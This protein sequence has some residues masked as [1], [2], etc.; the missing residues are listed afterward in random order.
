MVQPALRLPSSVIPATRPPP[1]QDLATPYERAL[2]ARLALIA[3]T[4]GEVQAAFAVG[5]PLYR[6]R[7]LI[8]RSRRSVAS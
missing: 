1:S 6:N 4:P 7:S 3:A 2:A 8:V 5:V